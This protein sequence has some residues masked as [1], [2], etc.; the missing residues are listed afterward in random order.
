M[1]SSL[2]PVDHEAGGEHDAE[3]LR[4]LNAVLTEQA[5]HLEKVNHELVASE[6]RLRLAIATG[7]LGLWVWNATDVSNAGDW[8]ERLKEIMGLP[9]SAEV[10]HDLFLKCLHSE[11]RDRVNKAVMDAL[12][13]DHNGAYGV[14]YRI[15]HPVDGSEHWVTARGQAFFNAK[16]EAIR[17]IGTVMDITERKRAERSLEGLNLE[18]EARIATR[19]ADLEC[20]NRALQ[21]EIEDRKKAEESLKRNKDVLRVAI[22]TIPALVWSSLPDGSIDYLNKRWL[23]YT[24]LTLEEATGWGWLSAIHPDDIHGLVEYWTSLLT[25]EQEGEIEARLRRYDGAYRWFLFRGVPLY[26]RHGKVSKWYGTN[27]DVEAMRASQ[28]VARGQ[29]DALKQTLSALTLETD[30]SK[31]LEH[32]L[33]MITVQMEGESS[34]VWERDEEGYLTLKATFEEDALHLPQAGA[35]STQSV[36]LINSDHPVWSEVFSTGTGCVTAELDTA[37][38]RVRLAGRD[39]AKWYPWDA[40]TTFDPAIVAMTERLL[41]MGVVA[42]LTVP[43]VIS[44]RVAGMIGIRFQQKRAFRAEEVELT[45]ALA[46]Q[47]ML[48][49]QLMR[50]SEESREAA[51]VAERN[52]LARDI[53]DTLAQG[54][55]GIIV[56]L[57]AAEDLRVRGLLVDADRHVFKARELARHSLQEARR[58]V[59][60]LRPQALDEQDLTEAIPALLRTM[61]EGTMLDAEFTL[62][63]APRKLP[64]EME[65]NLLRISQEVLANTLRH[66]H[67]TRFKVRLA[68]LEHEVH[69]ELRDDGCG[70]NPSIRHGRYGLLGVKERVEGLQ[71]RL[72]VQSS[73]GN[74]TFIFIV[75]PLA[76]PVQI[77]EP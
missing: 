23:D 72:D 35:S 40:G 60:A 21:K 3:T 61:T 73:P 18:L 15:V 17:F 62:T 1:N 55:T 9:L 6:Q 16:G 47:A 59:H 7:R 25:A 46:H 39:G 65:D 37:P 10:T 33:R 68:Y 69:L 71:G 24:G 51:V 30:P 34:S 52:R 5:A 11:D 22:D 53:H 20:A 76:G 74:G 13:G 67:A 50:L 19:T 48:A 41:S 45:R 38:P 42:T 75:L 66:A 56:Q 2:P 54:F 14:E 49:I 70:F 12:K 64:A 36:S 28:H 31:L 26:D 58:S 44:G 8:S 29:L 32:V 57:E 77:C 27:T 4:K 43:M 63:G